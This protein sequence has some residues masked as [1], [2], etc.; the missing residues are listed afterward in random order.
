[1]LLDDFVEVML[2]E[3]ALAHRF[4]Q[5]RFEQVRADECVIVMIETVCKRHEHGTWKTPTKGS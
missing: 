5:V 4:V 3:V 2:M 1:M